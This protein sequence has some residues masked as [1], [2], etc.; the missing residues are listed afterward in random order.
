MRIIT[1]S[2]QFGSGGRELGK[3]MAEILGFDF[4]DREIITRLAEEQGLE[5]EYVSRVLSHHEWNTVPRTYSHSFSG[6]ELIPGMNVTL[7]SR[8]REIIKEIAAAGNDCI[9]VGRNAD[10]ILHEYKPFRVF[11]C[12]DMEARIQRC[13]QHENKKPEAQRLTEKEIK[14]NMKRIERERKYIRETISGRD[15]GDGS[16][17]ELTVNAGTWDI[18]KLAPAVA[19]FAEKWFGSNT[20]NGHG[21]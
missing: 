16:A 18:E 12:A 20:E 21:A 19:E 8:Q 7:L 15:S 6:A 10:V 9:I 17:F 5:P 2:R 14:R 4:Y 11:V 3:R 13:M 1:I